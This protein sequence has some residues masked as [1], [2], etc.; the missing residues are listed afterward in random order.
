MKLNF[1]N[2]LNEHWIEWIES[3]F[4]WS[5]L[6]QILLQFIR[7]LDFPDSKCGRRPPDDFWPY[8]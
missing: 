3:P 4:F 1:L 6:G 7:R 5:R 8:I 2:F